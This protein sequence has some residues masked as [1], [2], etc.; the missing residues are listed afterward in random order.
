[1]ENNI[2]C[3]SVQILKYTIYCSYKYSLGDYWKSDFIYIQVAKI[4]WFPNIPITLGFIL[5]F[6]SCLSI[7]SFSNSEKLG[8]HSPSMLITIFDTDRLLR[9]KTVRPL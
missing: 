8:F 4:V 9:I 7:T 6:P 1:M 5:D 2:A 3:F